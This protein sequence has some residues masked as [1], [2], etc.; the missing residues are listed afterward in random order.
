MAYTNSFLNLV[1]GSKQMEQERLNREADIK[2][3]REKQEREMIEA[4][5]QADAETDA[6]EETPEEL[7][8]LLDALNKAIEEV[9]AKMKT[10]GK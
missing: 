10:G 3:E 8:Q 7:Q 4:Q 1:E 6:P 5:Q 2:N 9:T